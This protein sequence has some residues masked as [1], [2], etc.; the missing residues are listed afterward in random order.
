MVFDISKF[1]LPMIIWT[2]F[3][4]ICLDTK[5]VICPVPSV[6]Q[7]FPI[8]ISTEY[9]VVPLESPQ[10]FT[11]FRVFTQ[12]RR[13]CTFTVTYCSHWSEF[14]LLIFYRKWPRHAY[15]VPKISLRSKV[16]WRKLAFHRRTVFRETR[17][18]EKCGSRLEGWR[19]RNQLVHSLCL[20]APYV[21]ECERMGKNS[22]HSTV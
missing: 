4:R 10:L 12:Q 8:S 17:R 21:F 19:W 15:E 1:C 3:Q 14:F 9:C 13:N 7:F 11:I 2:F 22:R 18:R 16:D 5:N 6:P 20:P